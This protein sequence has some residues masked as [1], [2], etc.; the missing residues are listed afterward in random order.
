MAATIGCT[1]HD[2]DIDRDIVAA[3]CIAYGIEIA[4]FEADAL[5]NVVS[6]ELPGTSASPKATRSQPL[7]AASPIHA[8]TLSMVAARSS[9]A[10]AIWARPTVILLSG[11]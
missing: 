3:C 11:M 1:F 2:T 8:T 6:E 7:P 9:Q 4:I 10:G 5:A